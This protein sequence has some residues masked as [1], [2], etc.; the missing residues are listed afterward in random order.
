MDGNNFTL[1]DKKADTAYHDGDPEKRKS[2]R[3][4]IEKRQLEI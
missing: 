1:L 3:D 2:G 4:L